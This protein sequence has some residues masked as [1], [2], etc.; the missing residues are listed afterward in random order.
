MMQF[1]GTIFLAMVF[2]LLS[3]C[4]QPNT[5]GGT[6]SALAPS[7][8]ALMA[9]LNE[10]GVQTYRLGSKVKI[11]LPSDQFFGVN[12]DRLKYDPDPR[13]DDI[14]DLLSGY[15]AT[16]LIKVAGYTDDIGAGR[17]DRELSFRQAQSVIA[18]LWTRG[19]V[20]H[21]FVA[22]GYGKA[23]D[24]ASNR[25]IW[26]SAQNRRIEILLWVYGMG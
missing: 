11:I 23:L 9:R 24:V 26:G 12:S 1:F 14:A 15:S 25:R 19:M 18:Y 8:P 16:G 17:N 20:S 21:R 10:S 6:A 2:L 7:S 4:A 13:L 22:Q 3:G 5:A